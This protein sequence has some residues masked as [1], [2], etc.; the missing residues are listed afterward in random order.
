[1]TSNLLIFSVQTYQFSQLFSFVVLCVCVHVCAC[2][3]IE[4]FMKQDTLY[5]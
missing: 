5:W 2:V 3:V 1:M 4:I